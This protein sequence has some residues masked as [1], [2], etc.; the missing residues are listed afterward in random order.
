M[1][2]LAKK[3]GI[4]V[5]REK[6]FGIRVDFPSS[7]ACK[8]KVWTDLERSPYFRVL[9]TLATLLINK[10]A[11]RNSDTCAVFLN[12]AL[13]GGPRLNHS[14]AEPGSSSPIGR[15]RPI[16]THSAVHHI[17]R[18]SAGGQFWFNRSVV[19]CGS[20]GMRDIPAQR[21]KVPR[22]IF[23]RKKDDSPRTVVECIFNHEEYEQINKIC[24][25]V[26]WYCVP[27]EQR[28]DRVVEKVCDVEDFLSLNETV[29]NLINLTKIVNNDN[30]E[31][32]KKLE[33]VSSENVRLRNDMTLFKQHVEEHMTI[34]NSVKSDSQTNNSERAGIFSSEVESVEGLDD[35]DSTLAG[36]CID[37]SIA[38]DSEMLESDGLWTYVSK[39][40]HNTSRPCQQGSEVNKVNN[41]VYRNSEYVSKGVKFNKKH[42]TLNKSGNNSQEKKYPPSKLL[43]SM[44][45]NAILKVK[46]KENS[47]MMKHSYSDVIKRNKDEVIDVND[48]VYSDLL[49]NS[50]RPNADNVFKWKLVDEGMVKCVVNKMSGSH[51]EDV[52]DH[53]SASILG[54]IFRE[55]ICSSIVL[56]S[57]LMALN[58]HAGV[59]AAGSLS[60][61]GHAKKNDKFQTPS[62]KSR[63][64]EKHGGQCDS[65]K[66]SAN[67]GPLPSRSP[68]RNSSGSETVPTRS[69]LA[70]AQG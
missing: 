50:T 24:D 35:K 32:V 56:M 64:R 26:K 63:N 57:T 31:I 18:R 19:V 37:T 23:P 14:G 29:K 21:G 62:R 39:Q 52:Y 13:S 67:R 1:E 49:S 17:T 43:P 36:R 8:D 9:L 70:A 66:L 51:S 3:I 20:G 16:T 47:S 46:V 7:I 58:K 5:G 59:F 30:A 34:S 41:R 42:D 69:D 55:D 4:D 33:C 38:V 27:C 68:G 11:A 25:K 28:I 44:D 2:R 10:V 6:P 40:K 22:G 45:A 12:L 65:Q 61:F 48:S 54:D 15:F 53:I 60:V